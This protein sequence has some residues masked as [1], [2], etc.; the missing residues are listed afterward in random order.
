MIWAD[1]SNSLPKNYD[2]ALAQFKTLEK[3][4]NQNS[5]L[6]SSY[7]ETIKEELVNSFVIPVKR[8]F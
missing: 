8:T 6:E 5:G 2:S 3:M 7:N 4:L 1:D